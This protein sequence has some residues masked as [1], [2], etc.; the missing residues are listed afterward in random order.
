MTSPLVF[1][2]GFGP[3]LD[4]S[5]N[6]SGEL[7]RLLR[8]TPPAE[9]RVA[10]VVLPVSFA[11]TPE[12]LES[13]LDEVSAQRP[14]VLLGLGAQRKSWFRLERR[15]RARL[16]SKKPDAEG[17]FAADVGLLG[18]GDLAT[19]L[20][21]EGLRLVLIE[22]GAADARVSDDAG[23]Y[24]CELTYYS[25]LRRASALGIPALFL[26]LPPLDVVDAEVQA[27]CLRGLIVE[28]VRSLAKSSSTHG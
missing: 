20:D 7:V 2:T 5:E 8:D 26:H 22:A 23:G 17:L 16:D 19:G 9:V 21:L 6:P 18:E 24:L 10:G 28:L 14:V 1:V 15:A 11:R 3:F 12:A 25:L 4:V 27:G 13:A